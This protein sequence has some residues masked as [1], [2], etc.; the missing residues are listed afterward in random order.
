[1][2]TG[3]SDDSKSSTSSSSKSRTNRSSGGEVSSQEVI[4]SRSQESVGE[5]DDHIDYRDSHWDEPEEARSE[6]DSQRD[7]QHDYDFGDSQRSDGAS[8]RDYQHDY[9][10]GDSQRDDEYA[11]RYGDADE[12]GNG[13]SVGG[14]HAESGF[15]SHSP[16]VEVRVSAAPAAASTSTAEEV[17]VVDYDSDVET[18][19]EDCGGGEE[20]DCSDHEAGGAFDSDQEHSDGCCDDSLGTSQQ[21]SGGSGSS[22]LSFASVRRGALRTIVP[23]PHRGN[24]SV[25]PPGKDASKGTSKGAGKAAGKGA[26]KGAGGDAKKAKPWAGPGGKWR[27]KKKA[28]A[29]AK[30]D[31]M[32]ASQPS[33]PSKPSKSRAKSSLTSASSQPSVKAKANPDAGKFKQQQINFG[34]GAP[35]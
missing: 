14:G 19:G 29:G 7:Y 18:M 22:A 6:G 31:G 24:T 3:I 1:M 21:A 26:G 35:T 10:F 20:S 2:S 5:H 34:G 28:S 11:D 13:S 8:Q 32:S 33:K 23:P 25:S 30:G 27:Y 4:E 15:E 12:G 9:D 16:D 17:I